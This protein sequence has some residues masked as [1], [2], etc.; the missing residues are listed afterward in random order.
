MDK[1]ALFSNS[2]S[3]SGKRNGFWGIDFRSPFGILVCALAVF[4]FALI[5]L[6]IVHFSLKA[7]HERA[8][9]IYKENNWFKTTAQADG[10][11]LVSGMSD[12]NAYQY[13]EDNC[14]IPGVTIS[15][16]PVGG[17][18]YE[19]ARSAMLAALS[20][21]IAKINIS[22]TVDNV[23]IV[24]TASDFKI[25]TNI[26]DLL[27]DALKL[28]RSDADPYQNYLKRAEI[29]QNG[30]EVGEYTLQMDEESVAAIVAEAASQLDQPPVEPYITLL[31]RVGGGKPGYGTGGDISTVCKTQSVKAPNGTVIGEI[32]FHTGSNG[33]CLNREDM[34]RQI[35]EAF[36][37][38]NYNAALTL[39]LEEVT[40]EGDVNTLIDSVRELSRYST[41]FTTSNESRARNVQKAA[42]MLNCIVLEPGEE[43]S[44]NELLGP[45][46]EELGWLPAHGISGGK[47]YIDTP[48][49]GICQVSS[50]LYNSLLLIGPDIRIVSRSHH[51]I[52]GSYVAMG[53]DAT[54]SYYGPDLVWSNATEAPMFLFAYADMNTKTV[55]T[56]VYGT[57]P[58]DGTHYKIWSETVEKL[59]PPEPKRIAEPL[60]PSGYSKMVISPRYGYVV[61]VYRQ[62]IGADG[63]PVGDAEKLYT[64]KYASVQGELHYGTGSSTLPIPNR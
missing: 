33:Y 63:Q 20:D 37:S 17:M 51:S 2:H 41:E 32:L 4:A 39:L 53:L 45:R 23:S 22:V 58:D 55:Y 54:V 29:A 5:S 8:V 50:T 24:L 52:P 28:G 38:K 49:G 44:Y 18:S 7:D 40:P 60:W 25:T 56:F 34:L 12:G 14:I 1:K 13:V 36:N 42:A 27:H 47:E 35:S 59:D 30:F 21:E 31:N 46:T 3:R 11:T 48:G 15:G 10:T 6:V 16:V 61:D 57:Q 43:L 19:N 64:D 26:N 62:L 9:R